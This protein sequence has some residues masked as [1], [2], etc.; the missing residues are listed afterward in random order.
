MVLRTD[1]LP[2]QLYALISSENVLVSEMNG[3]ICLTPV[4]NTESCLLGLCSDSDLTVD[5]FLEIK[6]RDKELEF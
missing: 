2:E 3:Q 5:R 4:T 6:R 1:S